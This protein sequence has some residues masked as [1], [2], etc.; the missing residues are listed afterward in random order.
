MNRRRAALSALACLA[1]AACG[2][3]STESE[4]TAAPTTEG[5]ET[6][7]APTTEAPATTTAA[8]TT[9][10]TTAAPTTEAPASTTA[11]TTTA[12]PPP[13]TEAPA[14]P[15]AQC[16]DVFTDGSAPA[17]GSV[18]VDLLG[19]GTADDLVE[20]FVD[21]AGNGALRLTTG[22]GVYSEYIGGPEDQINP[23]D[24][25]DVFAG[26][27]R[28]L[29]ANLGGGD[30]AF[31]VALFTADGGGCLTMFT[32][33]DRNGE[34]AR[35]IIQPDGPVRAGAFCSPG[36]IDVYGA[37]EDVDGTW[38]AYGAGYEAASDT[39]L[40]Y[41]GASDGYAEGL[42]VSELGTYEFDCQGV[43]LR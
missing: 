42:D 26:G 22:E 30:A 31:T 14:S 39:D 4:G 19:D 25:V 41:I 16:P 5:T 8:T 15:A 24:V 9:P 20:G 28:E 11:P 21:P 35:F 18:T 36:A 32:Y 29:V 33:A 3:T 38:I 37:E 27:A 34:E 43:V 12:S 6:T 2:S 10:P 7:A 13:S 17:F 1:L 23:I 40:Q